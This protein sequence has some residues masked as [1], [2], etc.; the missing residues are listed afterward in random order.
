V[1][2]FI[3]GDYHPELRL[4]C[5]HRQKP[6]HKWVIAVNGCVK[7][8]PGPLQDFPPCEFA[9]ENTV[10]V[11]KCIR[12]RMETDGSPTLSSDGTSLVGDFEFS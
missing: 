7:D 11:H 5:I 2:P 6:E 3:S 10:Y 12:K 9:F 4:Y 1:T 8:G